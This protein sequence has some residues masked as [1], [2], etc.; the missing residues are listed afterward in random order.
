MDDTAGRERV[1]R[2]EALLEEVE[3][4]G[5]PLAREKANE[6]AQAL[7]EL[8]GAG[9]ERMVQA[10]AEHDGDGRLAEAFAGDELVSHLLLLHDLHPVPLEERVR[11]ALE[12]VRPYLESHG[13]NV[14]LAGVE[15]G[16]VRLR[17]QG[18]CSGCPS[19]TA[20][21]KLAIEDAVLRAAPEVE[22]I[23]AEGVEEEA[24]PAPSGLVQ[25]E[26]SGALRQPQP[27][28]AWTMA[29]G[30][31]EVPG[32]GPVLKRVAGEDV[33]FVK[34][35]SDVY[36]YRP[37]CPSCGVSLQEAGLDGAT[38]RCAGCGHRYDVR[39]AGRSA[40]AA[41]LHLEPVPL[42]VDDTGLVKVALGSVAA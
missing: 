13:G 4:L 24:A 5:D 16:V 15:E 26:V 10:I 22:E 20:T 7:L 40:D 12:E 31:P 9:L 29:G 35:E 18:S 36:A 17:L 37:A 3:G 11:G 41:D 34:L 32:G 23:E 14:E 25:L 33:L 6:V 1:A 42:L 28:P 21:L 8:Y 19:S 39:L 27:G 2:V 38:L 30:V